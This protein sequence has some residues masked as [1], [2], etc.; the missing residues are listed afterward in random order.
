MRVSNMLIPND[1]KKTDDKKFRINESSFDKIV[2]H[3]YQV[4]LSCS[5]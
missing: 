1:G 5:K 2:K 4:L 3:F